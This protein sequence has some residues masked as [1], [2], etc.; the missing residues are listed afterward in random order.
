MDGEQYELLVSSD[1]GRDTLCVELH[2]VGGPT[3]E[4]L[5]FAEKGADG[6]VRVLSSS[7]ADRF[8]PLELAEQFLA[9]ARKL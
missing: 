2:D 4:V 8:I 6:R 1:A 7:R 9:A 3:P 5:C